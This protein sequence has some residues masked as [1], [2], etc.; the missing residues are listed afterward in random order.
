MADLTTFA[1][2]KCKWF[3][4]IAIFTFLS[5][6]AAPRIELT[7]VPPFGS[8]ADLEGRVSGVAPEACRVAVFIYVPGAGWWSKPYCNPQLTTIQADGTWKADIS[9]SATDVHASRVTA[10]LVPQG[11]NEA[12]VCGVSVLPAGVRGAAIASATAYR[13]DPGRRWLRFS[14]CD[15]WVKA[16]P[17]QVGPGPNYFSDSTNNVWVDTLGQLHL[18][19]THRSNLWQCAEIVSER[20]F[21]NGSYRFELATAAAA[22][23]P[24]AVL[25]L[26]TWSDDPAFA[27]REIDV[28]ISRWGL[29]GQSNNAQFVVQPYDAAQHL[30][31]YGVP[32]GVSNSTHLFNWETNR[33]VFQSLIGGYASIP[34]AGDVISNWTSSADIPQTGDENVRINLWLMKGMTPTQGQEVEVIIKSFQFVPP[35]PP[36]GASLLNPFRLRDGSAGFDLLGEPDRQYQVEASTNLEVWGPL[37]NVL[38]GA[39]AARFITTNLPEAPL[40]FRAL[41][42]P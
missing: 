38:G 1:E 21:G 28:E 13:Q 3:T 33:V 19:I 11:Y 17:G 35:G 32:A 34:A 15:W 27:H 5:G 37:G 8:L 20:T 9:T 22:L 36:A 29:A 24:N 31:R 30:A 39:G 16:S 41:T 2:M 14:G 18:R 4:T 12:C 42:M 26:F 10:L 6:W 25:G 40:F 7:R 23:D